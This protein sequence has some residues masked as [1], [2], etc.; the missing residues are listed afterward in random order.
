MNR[1]KNLEAGSMKRVENLEA[2]VMNLRPF[3]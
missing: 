3:R 1:V 2:S